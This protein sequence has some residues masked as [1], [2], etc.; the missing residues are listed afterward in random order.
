MH[1]TPSASAGAAICGDR[2]YSLPTK[3]LRI[4]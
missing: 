3:P 1:A 2:C 4:A